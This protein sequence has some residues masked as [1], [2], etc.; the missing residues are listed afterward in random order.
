[1]NADYYYRENIHIISIHLF[2]DLKD[3]FDYLV[4]FQPNR[5]ISVRQPIIG[6]WTRMFHKEGIA[7][8]DISSCT[9]KFYWPAFPIHA[10]IFFLTPALPVRRRN[11]TVSVARGKIM[12][13]LYDKKNL[14]HFLPV[15][16]AI[17]FYGFYP[18]DVT[19]TAENIYRFL[20][21][22]YFFK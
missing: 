13:R 22:N 3:W 2:R 17:Q 15:L 7:L 14:N 4:P 11:V 10:T 16:S 5:P 21:Q 20:K 8:G 18:H 6:H 1:M 9:A 19:I 12:S